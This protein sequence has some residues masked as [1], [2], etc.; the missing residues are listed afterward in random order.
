MLVALI[1]QY[2]L[3]ITEWNTYLDMLTD[4]QGYKPNFYRDEKGKVNL[5]SP[6]VF[7]FVYPVIMYFIYHY[8]IVSKKSI[9]EIAL[10]TSLLYALWDA[11]IF[12]CFDKANYHIPILM[13]DTFVVGGLGVGFAAYILYNFYDVLKQY[14]PALSILYILSMIA[15]LKYAYEYN[16]SFTCLKKLKNSLNSRH[17]DYKKA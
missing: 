15:F 9:I 11:A 8:T 10:F 7:I 5:K 13:Y 4:I 1:L 3:L 17:K 12:L 14:I 16:S 6:L 2:V